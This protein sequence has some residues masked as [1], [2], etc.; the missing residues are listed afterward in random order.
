MPHVQVTLLAFAQACDQLGFH[1][2]TVE[3]SGTET[4]RAI[5]LRVAPGAT[6]ENMRVAVNQEYA[7]WDE[8]VGD[9]REIAVIPP[10]SG[11]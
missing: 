6:L 5:V 10:V 8:P 2:R 4:P 9:A 3:C 1:E 7:S 11:G